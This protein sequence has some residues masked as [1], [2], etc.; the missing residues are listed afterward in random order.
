MAVSQG[1]RAGVLAGGL[2]CA[3]VALLW[4]GLDAGES[5]DFEPASS[6]LTERA[7]DA[8]VAQPGLPIHP[9]L[10]LMGIEPAPSQ[11]QLCTPERAARMS[12]RIAARAD[13]GVLVDERGWA[14]TS[15]GRRAGLASYWSKCLHGGAAI[16][17]LAEHDG[18]LLAVYDPAH[19]L[20]SP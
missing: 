14:E 17:V 13:G 15:W 4:L 19:G 2:L 6:G 18:A 7:A 1:V 3:L 20:S 5:V 9:D 10:K 11:E 16:N 12:L 8:P